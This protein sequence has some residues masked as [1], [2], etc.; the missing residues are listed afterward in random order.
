V[1]LEFDAP[2]GK[3]P[4][5]EAIEQIWT[6]FSALPQELALP[7]APLHPIIVRHEQNRPQPARDRDADKGMAV[8]V[9]RLRP[10]KVFDIR[11]AALSH[12]TKRGAALGGILNAELLKAKGF[13]G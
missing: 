5:L 8:V 4:S 13:F 6:R 7:S 3:K 9:G 10:C 2:A 12:N 11:F 1:S